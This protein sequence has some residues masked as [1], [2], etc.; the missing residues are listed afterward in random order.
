[1]MASWS[2]NAGNDALPDWSKLDVELTC[3]R[4]GY[5]LRLLTLPRCPECGLTFDW[6]ELAAA[7]RLRRDNPL[8]EYQWR[9]WPVRSLLGTIARTLYPPWLWQSVR[10]EVEPR[11]GPLLLLALIVGIGSTAVG[12]A[13]RYGEL[14]YY[15]RFIPMSVLPRLVRDLALQVGLGAAIWLT[16]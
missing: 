10:L 6:Q 12:W 4:C 7:E 5:N 3:P 9:Y 1:M 11:I 2:P 16:L 14:Y 13:V 8:F 15:N